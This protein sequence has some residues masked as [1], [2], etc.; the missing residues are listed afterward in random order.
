[1]SRRDR[2]VRLLAPPFDLATPHP[3][4]IRGYPPGIRE[5]GGQYSHAAVWL[6]WAFSVLGDGD[7]TGELFDLL[8]PILR[9]RGPDDVRLYRVEPYV[10]AADIGGAPP[11]VGRGGW[12]WYTGSAGWAW[13]LG[14]ERM[15]G[16][17]LEG[18]SFRIQPCIPATWPGYDMT[19]RV[20]GATYEIAVRR[21]EGTTVETSL[22]GL[23]LADGRVPVLADGGTH[24]VDVRLAAAA[25]RV[26]RERAVSAAA[27]QRDDATSRPDPD[28]PSVAR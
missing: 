16:L 3:G 10:Y 1:M 21:G 11:Y 17:R 14:V 18:R 9:T 13:R 2:L 24:R 20:S 5:N 15:L 6:A 8:N 22:D 12:T 23:V 4:Y 25:D 28:R 7:R 27:P 26:R 19:W